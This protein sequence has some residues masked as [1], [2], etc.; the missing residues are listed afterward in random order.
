MTAGPINNVQDLSS[1]GYWHQPTGGALELIDVTNL[2]LDLKPSTSCGVD[3]LTS[4]ILKACGPSI[5]PVL[6]HIFNLSLTS[7]SFPACW[8]PAIVTPLYKDGAKNNPSNYRPISVLPSVG[9][10][11]ERAVHGQLYK[12][13]VDHHILSEC[14]SGFRKGHSTVTCLIDFL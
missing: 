12:Y 4:R 7:R 14:Q 13:L 10:L 8:K 9:K 1:C 11:M 3:G 6:Q 5:L 2:M